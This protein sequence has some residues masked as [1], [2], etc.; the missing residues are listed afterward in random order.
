MK[1]RTESI[2]FMLGFLDVLEPLVFPCKISCLSLT[3]IIGALPLPFLQ[4]RRPIVTVEIRVVSEC[5][6]V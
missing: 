5:L 6:L 2:I 3:G 1:E 4:M